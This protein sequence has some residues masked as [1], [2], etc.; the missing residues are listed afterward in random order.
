MAFQL[1]PAEPSDIPEIVPLQIAAFKEDP[2][3]GKLMPSVTHQDHYDYYANFLRKHWAEKQL[4]GA[5]FHKIVDTET[6]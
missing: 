4:R 5:V 6:G 3:I 2:I 1:L